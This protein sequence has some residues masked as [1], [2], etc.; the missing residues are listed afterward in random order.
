[1][2]PRIFRAN[3]WLAQ[4]IGAWREVEDESA[5]HDAWLYYHLGA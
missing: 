2:S 5:R 3:Y 4:Q 1:M